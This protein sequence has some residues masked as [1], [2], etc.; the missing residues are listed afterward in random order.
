MLSPPDPLHVICGR[1]GDGG[2]VGGGETVN[3]MNSERSV[4]ANGIASPN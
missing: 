1:K 3:G 4:K 2:E